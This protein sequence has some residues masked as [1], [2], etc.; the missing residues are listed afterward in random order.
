MHLRNKLE[1]LDRH[2]VTKVDR[3]EIW[4]FT[5]MPVDIMVLH[6]ICSHDNEQNIRYSV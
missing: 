5:P 6:S 2:I 1:A 3:Q 4:K